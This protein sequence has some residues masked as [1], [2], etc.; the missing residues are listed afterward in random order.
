MINGVRYGGNVLQ[1]TS[2]AAALPRYKTNV[3]FP[4]QTEKKSPVVGVDSHF[5]LI[6]VMGISNQNGGFFKQR[7]RIL[8]IKLNQPMETMIIIFL[9]IIQK[10]F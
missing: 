2:N 8:N 1:W 6:F 4:L 3:P 10:I 9:E 5:M 7:G